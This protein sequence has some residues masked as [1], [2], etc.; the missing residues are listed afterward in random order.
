M[1]KILSENNLVYKRNRLILKEEHCYCFEDSLL[2]KDVE[3][4]K[5]IATRDSEI[6][7]R[8]TYLREVNTKRSL[9][10]VFIRDPY[11]VHYKVIISF[12][13]EQFSTLSRQYKGY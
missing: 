3:T 5:K 11:I 4:S 8:P 6:M 13:Y 2:G 10:I 12:W 9:Y 7:T 1:A